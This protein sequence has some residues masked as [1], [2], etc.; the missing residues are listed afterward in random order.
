MTINRR[1]LI[2]GSA[3]FFA[4]SALG[5]IAGCSTWLKPTNLRRDDQGLL[6]LPPGFTY[7]ILQ[8]KGNKMS[9]GFPVPGQPDGMASFAGSNGAVILMRNHELGHGIEDFSPLLSTQSHDLFYQPAGHGAVSRL[10]IEEKTLKVLSSNLVL[11]GSSRNCAGGPSPWGWVSCEETVESGHGFAF[12]CSH[13]SDRLTAPQKLESLG[14]FNHEAFAYDPDT[15]ISYLTEDRGDGCLYRF[16]PN[17]R[18]EPFGDG[19]LQALAIEGS[20]E[21]NSSLAMPRDTALTVSWVD[22]DDPVPEDDSCRYQAQ[23]KGAALI[24]R[25]EGLWYHNET[26]YF[27]A[28][29]GGQAGKGQIFQLKNL[30]EERNQLE[31]I[32]ESE[33]KYGLDFPDNIAASPWGDIVIAEDGSGT[34]YIRL[35]TRTG[36][37]TTIAR[38][39]WSKGELTGVNFSPSGNTLFVNIQDQ[40]ITFAIRG[41]FK[42]YAELAETDKDV[43][44]RSF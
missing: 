28:T 30:A 16:V 24:S 1:K 26:I 23:S 42:K 7:K 44:T 6:D 15:A 39:Q 32:C 13:K 34:D 43:W 21:F 25:G 10:V 33:N 2:K 36:G 20:P 40:G 37:F 27:S 18:G 31:L 12:L 8:R 14:R 11:A 19:Q 22:I 17:N 38:N 41:P 4:L 5:S 9:D 29:D 3:G 35:L